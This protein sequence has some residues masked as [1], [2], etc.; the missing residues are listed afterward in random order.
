MCTI[1]SQQ[2]EEKNSISSP[3]ES[4]STYYF[5]KVLLHHIQR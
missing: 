4:F 1:R 2:L 3:L 5:L